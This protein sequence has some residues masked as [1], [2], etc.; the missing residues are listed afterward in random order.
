MPTQIII[1]ILK[2]IAAISAVLLL[3]LGIGIATGGFPSSIDLSDEELASR[4]CEKCGVIEYVKIS[5]FN[6]VQ[7]VAGKKIEGNQLQDAR[8]VIT[9]RMNSGEQHTIAQDSTPRFKSGE[10]VRIENNALVAGYF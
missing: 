9:V 8:F 7:S 6:G 5:S 10:R 2:K 4:E 3:L 1:N